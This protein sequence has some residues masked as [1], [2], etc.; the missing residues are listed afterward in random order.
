MYSFFPHVDITT[1]ENDF[2]RIR[3]KGLGNQCRYNY[4]GVYDCVY[5]NV[6]CRAIVC[7]K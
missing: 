7:I 3:L 2:Y 5:L 1:I 6:H 4:V